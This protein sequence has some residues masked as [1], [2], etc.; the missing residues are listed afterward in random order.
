[1]AVTDAVTNGASSVWKGA[2]SIA[3]PTAVAFTALTVIAA[4]ATPLTV[5]AASGPA[6][7]GLQ[8]STSFLTEML[9]S[10]DAALN[11]TEV[12]TNTTAASTVAA[13]PITPEPTTGFIDNAPQILDP[14]V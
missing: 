11:G 7:A 3:K 2:T 14:S 9:G 12:A 6:L 13:S 1:M 5:A 10:A 4:A 8:E